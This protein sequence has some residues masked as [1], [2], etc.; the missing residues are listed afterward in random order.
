MVEVHG[1][2]F[3]CL[4]VTLSLWSHTGQDLTMRA[5]MTGGEGEEELGVWVEGLGFRV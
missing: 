3:T 2:A 5:A 4:S 1:V